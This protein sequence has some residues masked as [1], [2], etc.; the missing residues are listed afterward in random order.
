M[1]K[2]CLLLLMVVSTFSVFAQKKSLEFYYISHDRTTPV[3][4]LCDRLQY[5]Y[6][7]AL[8]DENYAVIFYFPNLEDHIEV[9]V[10]LEGD[11]R[12][13][14][15]KILGALR[16]RDAHENYSYYD[17]ETI[18]NLMNKY[19]F[20]T[21]DGGYAYSSVLFCWYV[22]PDF[23]RWGGNENVIAKL[24]FT[25]ELE[26]YNDYVS[27]Q[28]WHARNDGLVLENEKYPFG[29][30]NLCKSMDFVLLSY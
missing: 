26:K 9:K 2:Y 14:F 6:E 23:W 15:D 13:D 28:V 11:N 10:N 24:Y 17:F 1:K 20:I 16:G 12:N 19:D 21:P 22:T 8:S 29:K 5:V 4:R 7:Q 3:N 25:L 30:L 27:T 18:T